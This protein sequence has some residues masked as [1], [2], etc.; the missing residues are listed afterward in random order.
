M[1]EVETYSSFTYQS[2]PASLRGWTGPSKLDGPSYPHGSQGIKGS[3]ANQGGDGGSTPRNESSQP[4]QGLK[5]HC[6]EV[7]RDGL[8]FTCQ[9]DN[10]T[11][12]WTRS[13]ESEFRKHLRKKH[14][15]EDD[16]IDEK[17]GRRARRR[18]RKG[19]VIK[20]D[21]ERDRQCP[22]EPQQ[23]PLTSSLLDVGKDAN[24]AFQ[25]L[26]PSVAYNPWLRHGEP[27]FRYSEGNGDP[28]LP[29]S[30]PT[31]RWYTYCKECVGAARGS[32]WNDYVGAPVSHTPE[33]YS[34]SSFGHH[35]TLDP[36]AQDDYERFK[37]R[38]AL[39]ATRPIL[40]L[41]LSYLFSDIGQR[42]S[43]LA[44]TAQ[45]Y[46]FYILSLAPFS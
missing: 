35:P 12:E 1:T 19:S 37:D 27:N 15:L 30:H 6:E 32:E 11:H 46:T 40:F 42:L 20:G 26:E 13:R 36:P 2:P 4:L 3:C 5:R 34:S 38:S 18:C 33:L 17:L 10:C 25:P 45:L 7:H 22:A 9:E 39:T 29:T 14:G 23:R 41:R 43:P 44:A 28:L 8:R 24:H 31:Q 21:P 16:K